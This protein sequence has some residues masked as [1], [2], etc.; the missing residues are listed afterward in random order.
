MTLPPPLFASDSGGGEAALVLLHGFGAVHGVWNEVIGS[1]GRA[2]RT[3]AYDLPGHGASMALPGTRPSAS[4]GLIA[5]DLQTRGVRQAHLV[6]H[7]MGGAIATLIALSAPELVKSL[8]LLS[9]GGF[10]R[11]INGPLLRRYAEAV[12][13]EDIRACLS[14][15][16]A[17]GFDAPQEAVDV[18]HRMRTRPGQT[19]SLVEI[20]AAITRGDRQG[21]IPRE[22]L[23][24]LQMPVRILWGDADPVLPFDQSSGLPTRF[25]VLRA[26]GA[27]H[28]L[29][30]ERPDMV[31]ALLAS[32]I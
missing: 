6:G 30:E 9:P 22:K 13:R 29:I 10:G 20:A 27:G 2:V 31:S 19:E 1:H 11:E 16:A 26:E 7:S 28:M 5:A 15:M 25:E 18:L 8:T 12:S 32:V 4:A 24:G 21:E 14:A 17:P 23:A 3:I